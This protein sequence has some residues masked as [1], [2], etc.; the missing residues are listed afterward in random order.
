MRYPKNKYGDICDTLKRGK[1]VV[2]I[3]VENAVVMPLITVKHSIFKAFRV[4][5]VMWVYSHFEN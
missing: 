1:A 5:C 4:V 3:Q 2:D